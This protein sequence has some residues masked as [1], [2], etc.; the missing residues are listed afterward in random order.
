MASSVKQN[1][2]KRGTTKIEIKFLQEGDWKEKPSQVQKQQTKQ[3]KNKQ[4]KNKEEWS[5]KKLQ[6]EEKKTESKAEGKPRVI[7]GESSDTV[8]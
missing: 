5:K 4:P 3:E 6:F 7:R 8:P 2:R 1:E